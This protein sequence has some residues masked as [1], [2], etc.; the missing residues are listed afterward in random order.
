MMVRPGV[1]A[2]ATDATP[3]NHASLL[4]GLQDYF[5]LSPLLGDAAVATPLPIPRATPY[6]APAISGL[7]PESGSVGT[8][9]SDRRAPG[10][11]TRTR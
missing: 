8:P 3:Y 9:V 7:T 11:R 2:G 4:A 1:S 5:G 10:S 6:P